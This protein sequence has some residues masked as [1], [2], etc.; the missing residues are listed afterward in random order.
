MRLLRETE[1]SRRKRSQKIEPP[2]SGENCDN[3]ELS[4]Y[5]KRTKTLKPR[6]VSLKF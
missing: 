5:P 6:R 4:G 2:E 3:A 1:D